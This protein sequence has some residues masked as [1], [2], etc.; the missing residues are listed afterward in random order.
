MDKATFDFEI[1][2]M[3]LNMANDS[4]DT[5]SDA[6][7]ADHAMDLDGFA[8]VNGKDTT[9]LIMALAP[10]IEQC[11]N[12]LNHYCEAYAQRLLVTIVSA[13]H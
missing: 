1:L 13:Y 6:S 10:A 2:K 4:F 11:R 5:R 7:L 12:G 3:V 9:D 8:R